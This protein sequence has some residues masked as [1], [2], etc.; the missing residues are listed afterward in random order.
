ME[1]TGWPVWLSHTSCSGTSSYPPD[2]LNEHILCL[3]R[4]ARPWVHCMVGCRR[5]REGPGQAGLL[6]TQGRDAISVL[7]PE[8]WAAL[9]LLSCV[10]RK[11]ADPSP[12]SDCNIFLSQCIESIFMFFTWFQCRPCLF[13]KELNASFAVRISCHHIVA[14]SNAPKINHCTSDSI[15]SSQHW[16]LSCTEQS[17]LPASCR[18][19]TVT[20]MSGGEAHRP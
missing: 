6:S 14:C 9:D 19:V 20:G 11:H 12:D 13:P 16:L 1:G 10:A 18:P 3:G 4:Q 5:H 7:C 15:N 17:C 8:G 2:A